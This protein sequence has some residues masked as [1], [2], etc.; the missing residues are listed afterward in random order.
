MQ[1]GK[2]IQFILSYKNSLSLAAC[3]LCNC[4]IM[5]TS[6]VLFLI[7]AICNAMQSNTSLSSHSTK[8][9][10]NNSKKMCVAC[11]LLFYYFYREQSLFSYSHDDHNHDH[12]QSHGMAK[13]KEEI[14]SVSVVCLTVTAFFQMKR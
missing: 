8:L 4:N 6:L 9:T 10:R 12:H 5:G 7:I 1:E 11:V 14:I 2:N 3:L 13:A